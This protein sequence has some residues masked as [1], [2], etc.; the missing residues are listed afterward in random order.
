[1]RTYI[2]TLLILMPLTGISGVHHKGSNHKVKHPKM[3]VQKVMPKN[4]AEI[5]RLTAATL[6]LEAGSES[7]MGKLGV[8]S[9]IWNRAHG[10]TEI[11]AVILARK[12]FSC[13]NHKQFTSFKPPKNKQY[14][15]CLEVAKELVSGNFVPPQIYR[16]AIAYHERSVHPSW[17][18]SFEMMIPVGHHL[19]YKEMNVKIPLLAVG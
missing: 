18:F 9:V 11:P 13:W 3:V 4:E 15:Y 7:N 6:Y 16:D 2:I 17:R 1:M 19:F 14:D 10:A 5:V 12:Q 8:A